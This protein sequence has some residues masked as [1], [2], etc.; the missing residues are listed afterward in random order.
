MQRFGSLWVKNG[1]VALNGS[2]T[3][4]VSVSYIEVGIKSPGWGIRSAASGMER[5]E[6]VALMKKTRHVPLNCNYKIRVKGHD[7]QNHG[8]TC[9][10]SHSR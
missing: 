1:A 9:F 2:E 3:T 10:L 8:K 5:S 4:N 6:N 7:I